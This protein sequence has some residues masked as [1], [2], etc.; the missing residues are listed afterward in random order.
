[1]PTGSYAL[2]GGGSLRVT[3]EDAQ[4]IA[5]LDIRVPCFGHLFFTQIPIAADGRFAM[6]RVVMGRSSRFTVRVDGVFAQTHDVQLGLRAVGGGCRSR[7][8]EAAGRPS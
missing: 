8:V 1:V 2:D 4:A 6:R 5:L 3:R 7:T